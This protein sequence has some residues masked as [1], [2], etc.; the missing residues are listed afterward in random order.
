MKRSIVL[1]VLAA[2]CQQTEKEA[3]EIVCNAAS[4]VSADE[5]PAN[6]ATALAKYV[7]EKVTNKKVRD[8]LASLAPDTD[9]TA[10]ITEMVKEA[11]LDPKKCAILAD[12][13]LQPK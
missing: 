12:T 13:P 8:Q 1:L 11:G 7:D 10:I 6:R 9:R 5:H 4:H 3:W 2:G